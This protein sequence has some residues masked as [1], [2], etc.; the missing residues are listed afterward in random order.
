MHH[1]VLYSYPQEVTALASSPVCETQGMFSPRK[2]LTLQGHPEFDGEMMIALL[3]ATD[4]L[5][6]ND[7][8]LWED[9]MSKTEKSHDGG[10]VASA[11]VRFMHG[12][13]DSLGVKSRKSE[14][15]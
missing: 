11:I 4:E 7:R 12:E 6:F 14:E 8:S 13:F 10:L 15:V 2:L 1:D 9:A 5:G 3:E